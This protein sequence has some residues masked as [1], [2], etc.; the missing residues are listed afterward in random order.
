MQENVDEKITRRIHP[1]DA[2]F[3][4]ERRQRQWKVIVRFGAEPDFRQTVNG[5]H[6]RVFRQ[7][8]V[9]VPNEARLANGQIGE[10]RGD[11]N[12][13]SSK[14]EV[15]SLLRRIDLR[16]RRFS[17][18][19]WFLRH[20]KD[21]C[22]KLRFCLPKEMIFLMSQGHRSKKLAA[23]YT[24]EFFPSSKLLGPKSTLH[25][26]KASMAGRVTTEDQ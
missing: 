6:V 15:V 12:D 25:L 8:D 23:G 1:P 26:G 22:E 13:D 17:F 4:P 3:N 16:C 21:C 24:C 9:V 10:E 18:C 5:S 19:V 14:P 11:E 20:A 7:H 2:P